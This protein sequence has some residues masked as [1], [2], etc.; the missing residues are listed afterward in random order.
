VQTRHSMG[1]IATH[2][3]F[4][5]AVDFNSILDETHFDFGAI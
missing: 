2:G 5:L 1:L 3:V 4:T